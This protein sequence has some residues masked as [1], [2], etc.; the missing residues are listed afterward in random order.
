MIALN[1]NFMDVDIGVIVRE[2]LGEDNFQT[3]NQVVTRCPSRLF[4][5]QEIFF[6]HFLYLPPEQMVLKVV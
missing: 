3:L 5:G 1:L 2:D 6:P 4:Y